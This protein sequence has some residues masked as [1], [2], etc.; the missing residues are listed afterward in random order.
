MITFK[1]LYEGIR[2]VD[3]IQRKKQSRRMAKL[4]KSKSFQFKKQKA[5]LRMRDP[6]KL[7]VAAKKKVINSFRDKFYPGYNQMSLQQR[8]V[9]DSLLNQKYGKKNDKIT[10]KMVMKLKKQ[11]VERVKQARA[12]LRDKE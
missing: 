5:A 7:Q 8:V 10:K 9:A 2:R 6:A 11:E 3:V 4:A 12:A 1:K